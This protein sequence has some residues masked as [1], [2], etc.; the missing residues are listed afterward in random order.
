MTVTLDREAP[1][2]FLV[3]VAFASRAG[4]NAK[5]FGVRPR[6]ELEMGRHLRAGLR[7]NH[8]MPMIGQ[9]FVRENGQRDLLLNRPHQAC[10]DCVVI[11]VEEQPLPLHASMEH[12]L[13]VDSPVAVL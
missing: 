2:S 4:G 7:A 12:M 9:Q 5:S 13:L 1:K 6:Q 10:E 11:A 8:E 3:D